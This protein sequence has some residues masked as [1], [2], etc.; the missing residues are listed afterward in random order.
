[1][2]NQIAYLPVAETVTN[3]AGLTNKFSNAKTVPCAK[4]S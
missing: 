2:K 3:K 1:M 4:M